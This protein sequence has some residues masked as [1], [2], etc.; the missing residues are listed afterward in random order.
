[1]VPIHETG[2][3]RQRG[4]R[5]ELETGDERESF[6]DFILNCCSVHSSILERNLSVV[7]ALC[8]S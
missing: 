8:P 1:M 7:V 2:T 3:V 4:D 6:M 5:E